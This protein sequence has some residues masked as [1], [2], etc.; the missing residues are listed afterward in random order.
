MTTLHIPELAPDRLFSLGSFV[1]TNT[2]I[3]VWIALLIFLV[4]GFFLRRSL[5]LRPGKMQNFFEYIIESVLNTFDQVTGDRK[6]TLK[7][8][9]IVGTIFFFVL[10]SNWIG[11]L[12]G[13][14]SITY[15]HKELLRPAN[16]DLNLTVVMALVAVLGSHIMGLVTVG[17][18]THIGKYI[19]V[20]GIVKSFKK[21]PIA[22]FAALIEFM[23]GLLEIISEIAKVL[24][25]SLR[26][27]GNIFAGEVLIVVIRS[28]I[29]V[30]VPAPFMMLELL[31]G[32]IQAAVFAILTLVYFTI[33]TS[34]PHGAEAEEGHH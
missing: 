21:G 1:I 33:A 8:F 22:I 16:T 34:E 12:P 28:L 14:G 11:L 5:S 4:L 29:G 10:V 25:L 6:K 23:V 9:P 32:L 27:F 20:A 7:F 3:N 26:L 15:G 19:Q 13:I 30:V 31:V 2:M 18:F 17:V 24:S